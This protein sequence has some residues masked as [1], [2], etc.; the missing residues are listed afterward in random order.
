MDCAREREEG[1][2]EGEKRCSSSLFRPFAFLLSERER[3]GERERDEPLRTG[4]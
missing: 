2:K 1:G 4:A 3:G